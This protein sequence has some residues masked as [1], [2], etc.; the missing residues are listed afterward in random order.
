MLYN[1]FTRYLSTC[2]FVRSR[3]YVACCIM[4]LSLVSSVND[5][6]ENRLDARLNA[7]DT[8]SHDISSS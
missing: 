3:L 8:M 7:L 4:F 5:I 6:H 2:H 1:I